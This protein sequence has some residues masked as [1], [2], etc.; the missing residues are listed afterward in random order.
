MVRYIRAVLGI[1]IVRRA[2]VI[3]RVPLCDFR[4]ATA[5]WFPQILEDFVQQSKKIWERKG[6]AERTSF[7]SGLIPLA[8]RR[9]LRS[10]RRSLAF[11]QNRNLIIAVS[12]T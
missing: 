3:Y 10:R 12:K 4:R 7:A 2:D 1:L 5:G 9:G 11:Q 8:C 6:V